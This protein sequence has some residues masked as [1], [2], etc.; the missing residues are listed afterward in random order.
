MRPRSAAL[1]ALVLAVSALVLYLPALALELAGDDYQWVQHAHHALHAPRLLLADLDT[2]YRPASTWT[3]ALDRL[4]WGHRPLGYHL[5]N[6]LLHALAATALALAARRLG[7]A[8]GAAAAAAALWLASPFTSEPAIQVAIRFENLLLVAWL[9]LAAA[10]PRPAERWTPGRRAAV[11]AAA[12]LAAASKETWVVTPLLVLV[13]ARVQGRAPW[14]RAAAYC[15]AFAGAA[16]LYALAYFLAFPSGKGYFDLSAA[17]LAK[18][19]HL[20][21]AFLFLTPLQP[22]AFPLGWREALAAVATAAALV[23]LLRRG[24]PAGALGAA[25]LAAPLLPTLLVPYLPLRYAAIPW[26]GFA[27]VAAAAAVEAVRATR[28]AARRAAAAAATALATLAVAAGAIGVRLELLD[29]A[30]VSAAHARLLA[31]AAAIAPELPVATPVAV[32]RAEGEHPLGP[33]ARSPRGL[34]K[35]YYPRPPDPYGLIDAAALF[36]WALA[37]EGAFVL[38]RDDGDERFAGAGGAVLLHESGRFA[39]AA[40]ATPDVVGEASRWRARGMAVRWIERRAAP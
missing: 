10:W 15:G 12:A 39:W 34:F 35:L 33:L 28:G 1:L 13:L 23:L 36:E 8:T 31:E 11:V 19:P 29:A 4:A 14:R 18:V 40:R 30:R 37:R 38:R 21:A 16:A 26:A 5:T 32:V 9:A 2:F 6:L 27:L 20:L 22:L 25:L 7:L 24:S 17:P 3:L